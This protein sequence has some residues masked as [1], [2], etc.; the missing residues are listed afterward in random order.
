MFSDLVRCEMRTISA[1]NYEIPVLVFESSDGKTATIELPQD[2]DIEVVA[3][4]LR[5]KNVLVE[6]AA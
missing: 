1:Q 2:S 6:F 3:T 4:F 5:E